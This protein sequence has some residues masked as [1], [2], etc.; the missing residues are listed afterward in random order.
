VCHFA[1]A[2]VTKFQSAESQSANFLS[3]VFHYTRFHSSECHSVEWH[4]SKAAAA[5]DASF[6]PIKKT[7]KKIFPMGINLNLYPMF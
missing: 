4:G 5:A 6:Q 3:A 1:E 2:H 7:V